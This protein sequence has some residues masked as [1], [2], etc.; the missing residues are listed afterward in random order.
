MSPP[1]PDEFAARHFVLTS[2]LNSLLPRPAWMREADPSWQFHAEQV[3][4]AAR[5]VFAAAALIAIYVDATEPSRWA[6]VGYGLL[7]VYAAYSAIVVLLVRKPERIGPRLVFFCVAVDVLWATVISLFTQGPNSPFMLFFFFVLLTVAYRWGMRRTLGAALAFVVILLVQ[8]LILSRGPLAHVL[9]GEFEPN[10]LIIRA[11]YLVIFGFLT[12]YLAEV[13]RRL[14]CEVLAIN[15]LIRRVEIGSRF[16]VTLRVVA[17]ELLRWFGASRIVIVSH[18]ATS[19]RTYLWE[20][21]AGEAVPRRWGD[22]GRSERGNYLVPLTADAAALNLDRSGAV[23]AIDNAGN[24]VS[25]PEVTQCAKHFAGLHLL[26]ASLPLTGDWQVRVFLIDPASLASDRHAIRFLSR[27]A[28][29]V[30]PA[31]HNVYLSHNLRAQAGAAERARLARELHD[32]VI[33]ELAAIT[34]EVEALRRAADPTAAVQLE[35]IRGLVADEVTRV[36]ELMNQFRPIDIAPEQLPEFLASM[37][38]R[39]E[40]DSGISASFVCDLETVPVPRW[41]C[42]ELA[43]IVQE[44]LVNVRRHSG[45]RH[46]VVA[47]HLRDDDLQIAIDDDGKGFDFSGQ[48]EM[49]ALDANR[50]GPIVIKER[51]RAIGAELSVAS[52]PDRGARLELRYP[53]VR[54]AAHV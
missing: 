40:R 24:P 42:R 33:Q 45:A 50:K 25:P 13:E 3:L 48:F 54:K 5:L 29:Q 7:V 10:R 20:L 44:A 51:A 6:S 27:I 17:G 15:S 9:K 53:L 31:V 4:A 43:R 49:S 8:A 35:R 30:G 14:S 19:A 41:V 21:R 12:G 18:H 37:I 16:G 46:V 34:M 26:S 38:E 52:E 2:L 1:S 23:S 36:R 28:Q 39:F 11:A 47:M 32:G 22:V